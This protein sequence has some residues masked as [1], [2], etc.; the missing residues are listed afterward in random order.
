MYETIT[1]P[2]G[3]INPIPKF[4]KLPT[5]KFANIPVKILHG[6][7]TLTTNFDIPL[8]KSG[9]NHLYFYR[10]YPTAIN[11]TMVKTLSIDVKNIIDSLLIMLF[12]YSK[13]SKFRKYNN[14][15]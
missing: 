12:L 6:K 3:N 9:P 4:P 11:I 7:P 10:K 1:V 15:Y 2:N 14:P 13:I 8:L 5:V